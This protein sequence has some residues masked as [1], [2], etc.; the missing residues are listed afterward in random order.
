M[1]KKTEREKRKN[2]YN[3]LDPKKEIQN[4]GYDYLVDEKGLHL[5]KI[6]FPKRY[7][8]RFLPEDIKKYKE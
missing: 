6:A 2:L 3:E 1:I 4:I 5:K 7:N 8:Y